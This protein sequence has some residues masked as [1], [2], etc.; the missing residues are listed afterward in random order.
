MDPYRAIDAQPDPTEFVERLEERG[1]T[2]SHARL[3][4]R[5]LRFAGVR[6]GAS[7]L[8]VGSGSGV[9]ARDLARM[10]GPRGQI[11][12]VDPSRTCVAAARRIRATTL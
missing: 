4:R 9:V 12:G 6:G 1:E 7:V 10:V 11:V 2:P 8:E 5:F 3:R